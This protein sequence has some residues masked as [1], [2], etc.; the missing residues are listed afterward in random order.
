MW[1]DRRRVSGVVAA[2]IVAAWAVGTLAQGTSFNIRL[3]TVPIGP[4]EKAAITGHGMASA[5]LDGRE[6]SVNASFEGLQAPA[7]TATLRLGAATGVRGEAFA[8]LEIT[9]ATRGTLSGT[10]N[11][12]RS[13]LQA[14]REGRVY[15]QIDSEAGSEGNLWGWLLD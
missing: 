12:S 3:S 4:A 15:L 5:M 13:Q 6:L 9:H 2:L 1:Q 14:L 10:V 7:T 11:L 8:N